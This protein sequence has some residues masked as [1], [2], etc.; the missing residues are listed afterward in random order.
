MPRAV[1]CVLRGKTVAIDNAI[2]VR[3]AK[4]ARRETY[5][6]WR[7]TECNKHVLPHRASSQSAGHFEHRE[8]NSECSLSDPER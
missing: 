2:R 3:D 8:R 7:C 5:P 6:D 4:R 1:K